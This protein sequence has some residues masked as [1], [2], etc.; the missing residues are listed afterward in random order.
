MEGTENNIAK[1]K[2]KEV[3]IINTFPDNVVLLEDNTVVRINKMFGNST[4]LQFEG[5]TWGK[6]KPLSTY[7]TNSSH[8]KI[9]ELQ[10]KVTRGTVTYHVNSISSKLVELSLNLEET[11]SERT[12]VIPLLH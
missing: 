2:F 6:K 8:L 1:I 9:W 5:Q 7:P 11:R 12:F 10:E 4:N 3:T